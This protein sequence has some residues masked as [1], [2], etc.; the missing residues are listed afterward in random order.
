MIA[1]SK[2]YFKFINLVFKYFLVGIL[3]F[4]TLMQEAFT[5][6]NKII[7]LNKLKSN[8]FLIQLNNFRVPRF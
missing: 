4:K 5:C 2:Y 6:A 7:N 3:N 8:K 1:L